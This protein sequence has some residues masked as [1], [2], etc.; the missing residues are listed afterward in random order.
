METFSFAPVNQRDPL[1]VAVFEKVV[2]AFA[3]QGR[4]DLLPCY[5]G[6]SLIDTLEVV[7]ET[8]KTLPPLPST[9]VAGTKTVTP[10][11]IINSITSLETLHK[12]L[13]MYIW[14]SFRYDVSF[15][16]RPLAV[17]VKERVELVLDQCLA[18]LPGMKKTQNKL[19]QVRKGTEKRVVEE[20]KQGGE[21]PKIHY[22]SKG[23]DQGRRKRQMWKNVGMVGDDQ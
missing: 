19:K 7:E 18:R 4:V 2:T 21:K 10:P 13:V 17:E 22:A 16:D 9:E 23:E 14:L 6:S 12:S 5:E 11:I 3:K 8:L 15:P 20:K 1:S